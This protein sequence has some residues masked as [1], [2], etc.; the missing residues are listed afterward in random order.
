M[1]TINKAKMQIKTHPSAL[2]LQAQVLHQHGTFESLITNKS[3]NTS[4]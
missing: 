3:L 1:H 2:S 4:D